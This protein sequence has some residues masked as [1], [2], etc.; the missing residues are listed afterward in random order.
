[1]KTSRRQY[2][3][4]YQNK[5][6]FGRTS[7]EKPDAFNKKSNLACEKCEAEGNG[8]SEGGGAR[9]KE[10]KLENIAKNEHNRKTKQNEKTV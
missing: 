10:K 1:M 2:S 9:E 3:F 8:R 6:N 7:R 5:K 4:Y